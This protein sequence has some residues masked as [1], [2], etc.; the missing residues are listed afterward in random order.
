LIPI[1][2]TVAPAGGVS[3]ALTVCQS[4]PLLTLNNVSGCTSDPAAAVLHR[5]L[6]VTVSALPMRLRTLPKS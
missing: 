4:I 1:A 2:H 6:S 3:V 5:M